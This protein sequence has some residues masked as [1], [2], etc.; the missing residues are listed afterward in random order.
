MELKSYLVEF[1]PFPESSIT[2]TLEMTDTDE[3]QVKSRF[4]KIYPLY[5]IVSIKEF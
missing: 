5:N 3:A 1:R 4:E 2:A